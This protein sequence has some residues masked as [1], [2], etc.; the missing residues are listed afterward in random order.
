MKT[1]LKISASLAL[2]LSALGMGC[3][4]SANKNNN[5]NAGQAQATDPHSLYNAD[6]AGFAQLSTSDLTTFD[7]QFNN[8]FSK[9]FGGD[10]ATSVQTY[11]N[12]RIHYAFTEDEL[13][14]AT[15]TPDI[16]STRLVDPFK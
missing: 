14:Q 5:G 2:C 6:V 4:S 12:E 9:L 15:M 3:S 13:N 10:D 16:P 7:L 1:G 11:Y 8:I